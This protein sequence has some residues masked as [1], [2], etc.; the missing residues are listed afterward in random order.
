MT[1]KCARSPISA[2]SYLRENFCN[3]NRNRYRFSVNNPKE[4]NQKVTEPFAY[5]KT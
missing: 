1:K 4:E 3:R 5:G 2:V